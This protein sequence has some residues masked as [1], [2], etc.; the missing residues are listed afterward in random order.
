MCDYLNTSLS[1]LKNEKRLKLK[2]INNELKIHL[3]NKRKMKSLKNILFKIF[4]FSN[5]SK[6][7]K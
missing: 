7:Y 3:K 4:L 5:F 2:L 6:S 1:K